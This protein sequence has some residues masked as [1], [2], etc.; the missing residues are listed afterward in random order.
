MLEYLFKLK[1]LLYF[2][3]K[4]SSSLKFQTHKYTNV[5]TTFITVHELQ[6][7]IHTS[8][9]TLLLNHDILTFKDLY[10]IVI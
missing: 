1:K 7:Q 4:Y 2:I 9:I 8:S 5:V 6:A 3:L 10:D